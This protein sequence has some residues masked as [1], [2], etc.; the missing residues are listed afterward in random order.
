[1]LCWEVNIQFIFNP[2]LQEMWPIRK[3]HIYKTN[4]CDPFSAET[5]QFHIPVDMVTHTWRSYKSSAAHTEHKSQVEN[6]WTEKLL[7]LSFGAKPMGYW[8]YPFLSCWDQS[9]RKLK[10]SLVRNQLDYSVDWIKENTHLHIVIHT[11]HRHGYS[12]LLS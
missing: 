11:Q 6:K 2:I 4:K 8:K 10:L 7:A 12:L 5:K 9:K 1:M 3:K